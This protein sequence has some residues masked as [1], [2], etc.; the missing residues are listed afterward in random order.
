MKQKGFTLIEL[1]V[2]VAIIGILAAVGVVAYNGYQ[3]Y[4][5]VAAVKAQHNNTAKFI[6]TRVRNCSLGIPLMLEQK[7][8][9]KF[10]YL[11]LCNQPNYKSRHVNTVT[12]FFHRHFQKPKEEGYPCNLYG[13]MKNVWERYTFDG[14]KIDYAKYMRDGTFKWQR[15]KVCQYAFYQNRLH[16]HYNKGWL[17]TTQLLSLERDYSWGKKDLKEMEK[18]NS[19]FKGIDEAIVV[20]TQVKEGEFLTTIIKLYDY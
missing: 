1:L 15:N 2:V 6:A 3:N 13:L 7:S 19:D 9:G 17:G 14:K 5:K 16:T 10:Y 11:D 8:Y 18:N 4:A 12:G 20:N